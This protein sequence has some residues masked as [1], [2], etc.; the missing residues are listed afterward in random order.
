M[1]ICIYRHNTKLR[2]TKE[3]AN[4]E[5][6]M[7]QWRLHQFN[8]CLV[9]IS[10]SLHQQDMVS[11]PRHTHPHPHPISR[12]TI[13]HR[14]QYRVILMHHHLPHNRPRAMVTHHQG[15]AMV[16]RHHHRLPKG[17]HSLIILHLPCD[18]KDG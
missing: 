11:L 16:T 5:E 7:L 18:T 14:R 6:G 8:I 9:S 15:M 13:T 2:W 10:L 12:D 3:M 4:W 17:T 1:I